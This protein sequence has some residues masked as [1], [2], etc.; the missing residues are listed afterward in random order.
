MTIRRLRDSSSRTGWLVSLE[1]GTAYFACVFVVGCVLGPIREIWVI[2]RLGRVLAVLA[3][4]VVMLGVSVFLAQ[5]ILRWFA[6]PR[7]IGT[8]V[9]VGAI[10]F[11]LLQIAEAVLA[12]WL[13]G[14]NFLQYVFSFWSIPGTISL[15]VQMA[16]GAIPAVVKR[17]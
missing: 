16:F 1:A 14:Q 9:A 13:R 15:L 2:P 5:R 12:F 11:M 10:A 6:V 3:E 8:R 7:G 17:K 4:S